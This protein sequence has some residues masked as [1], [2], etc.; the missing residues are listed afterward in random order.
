MKLS[1]M[2]KI[3]RNEKTEVK[4]QEQLKEDLSKKYDQLKNH[5][6]DDLMNMLAEEVKQQK[7]KGSFDYDGLRSS[8]ERVKGYLPNSTYQNMLKVI[9]QFK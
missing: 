8:I 6:A 9:E 3:E 1:E 4:G 5:S 2:P 7:L